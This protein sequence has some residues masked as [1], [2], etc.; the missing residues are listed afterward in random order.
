MPIGDSI[1]VSSVYSAGTTETEEAEDISRTKRRFLGPLSLSY[2]QTGVRTPTST[3]TYIDADRKMPLHLYRCIRLVR[4]QRI[5][6]CMYG[7]TYVG[8]YVNV[9][10]KRRSVF[11]FVFLSPD[12]SEVEDVITPQ[13][14]LAQV[15]F[16][17]SVY[18]LLRVLQLEVHVLV[19]R[20]QIPWTENRKKE[21]MQQDKTQQVRPSVLVLGTSTRTDT[22]KAIVNKKSQKTASSRLV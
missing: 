2:I 11:V 20:L 6:T 1:D 13:Q 15:S 18:P 22:R 12:L 21:D 14:H 5:H 4:N 10:W 7:S 9:R 17:V 19:E 3:Y 8:A 16:E